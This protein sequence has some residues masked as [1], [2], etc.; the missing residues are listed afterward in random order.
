MSGKRERGRGSAEA[1]SALG[2]WGEDV[3]VEQLRCEGM[4]I[5]ERNARPAAYDRRLEIDIVA[6]EPSTDTM[7]FVEV[8][9]HGTHLEWEGVLRGI[10]ERKRRILKRAFGA[11]RNANKW[12]GNCRFD[13]VEVYGRPGRGRPHIDHV[14][15]VSLQPRRVRRDEPVQLPA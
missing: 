1:A 10:T 3:A 13:V 7:V 2:E 4:E 14:R 12:F 8:K 5:V 6:Y 9:Q 11:W 15:S